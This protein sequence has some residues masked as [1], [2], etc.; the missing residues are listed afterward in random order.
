[1]KNRFR[2]K[3][4][5]AGLLLCVYLAVFISVIIPFHHH[6]DNNLHDDCVICVATS[7]PAVFNICSLANVLT[8]LFI[9]IIFSSLA[10]SFRQK[11]NLHLRSPPV[12]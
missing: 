11:E 1:M 7:Q 6:A 12:F 9:I 5:L 8:V 4:N 3:L 10:I 2:T